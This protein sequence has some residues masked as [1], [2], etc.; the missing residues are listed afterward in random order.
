MWS[1]DSGTAEISFIIISKG[2]I[3]VKVN[4]VFFL[5]FLGMLPVR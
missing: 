2:H 3:F 1:K 5:I 4:L